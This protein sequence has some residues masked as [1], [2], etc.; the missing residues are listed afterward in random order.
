MIRRRENLSFGDRLKGL[1]LFRLEKRRLQ[2]DTT[3]HLFSNKSLL[4]NVKETNLIVI[5]Q[6]G[7]VLR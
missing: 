6:V 2:R 5:R 7:T 1:G 4:T 3:L